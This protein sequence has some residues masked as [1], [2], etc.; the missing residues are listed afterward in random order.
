MD[1]LQKNISYPRNQVPKFVWS[2]WV[3]VALRQVSFLFLFQIVS[4]HPLTQVNSKPIENVTWNVG[5]YH[6][7]RKS[8]LNWKGALATIVH[9]PSFYCYDKPTRDVREK[10]CQS[11]ACGMK[12]KPFVSKFFSKFPLFSYFPIHAREKKKAQN[13]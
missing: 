13:Q 1:S 3:Q 5:L 7:K 6:L 10:A 9:F 12:M 4:F 2:K 11:L 8:I